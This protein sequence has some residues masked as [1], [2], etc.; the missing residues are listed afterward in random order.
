MSRWRV[1]VRPTNAGKDAVVFVTRKMWPSWHGDGVIVATV[2]LTD[3][4][5][6]ERLAEARARAASYAKQIE[7]LE[8]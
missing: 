2:Q 6:D 7:G 3:E 5:A 8:G 4:N 1:R